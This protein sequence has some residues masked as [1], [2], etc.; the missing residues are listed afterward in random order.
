M[1][2]GRKPKE[3]HLRLVTGTHRADRHGDAVKVSEAAARSAANFGPL[4]RPTYLKRFAREPAA[5]AFCEL[6]QE[7]RLAPASFQAAKHS[8]MRG[9]MS[10]L[11]LTDE[12]NRAVEDPPERDEHFD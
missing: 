12:R 2:R 5:I 3:P 10:A 6:W 9:Y 11:G 7:M 4:I 1:A 8:Q